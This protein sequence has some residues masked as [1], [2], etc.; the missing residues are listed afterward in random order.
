M[1]RYIKIHTIKEK[2]KFIGNQDLV[3]A[4]RNIVTS[5]EIVCLYGDSGVGKT[6]LFDHV[7]HGL[8][9]VDYNQKD[10]ELLER[11]KISNAHV[12][13]DEIDLDKGFIEFIKSGG[14][15]SKG[16]LI[17]IQKSVSKIDFCNCIHFE[18][19]TIETLVQ[20]AKE[21]FPQ[22][23]NERLTSL[24]ELANGN[25]RNYLYSIDFLDVQDI[26]KTPKDFIH[27]LV[28]KGGSEDPHDYVG[29][30][31]NEHGYVWDIVHENYIDVADIDF[32]KIT[33]MMSQSD[34]LDSVIYE[35]NWELIPLFSLISTIVPAIEIDHRLV[36]ETMRPG[37]A[38]TK[39]GNYRMRLIKYRNISNRT[40]HTIDHDS[41]NL[42]RTIAQKDANKAIQIMKSY[43]FQPQD[44]DIMN[45]LSFSTKMK[46][47]EVQN[48]KKKLSSSCGPDTSCTKV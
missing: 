32:E 41:L 12:V 9:R 39:F 16:A 43:E 7:L 35:G 42:I 37:S 36:R 22:V 23:S 21:K 1:D 15:V 44:I 14:R 27:D 2:S 26:F 8:K 25:I 3:N 45:H 20:I 33:E 48:L 31:I 40:R 30:P 34:I 47:R 19:P 5:N 24:A 38:W 28:C 11:L 10:E 46:T 4:V 29:D 13:I 18:H 17:I 6:F